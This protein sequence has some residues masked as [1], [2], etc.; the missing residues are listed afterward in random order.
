MEFFR[1]FSTMDSKNIEA[2]SVLD[3]LMSMRRF[4][5]L[6]ASFSVAIFERIDIDRECSSPCAGCGALVARDFFGISQGV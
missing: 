4:K 6:E 2:D 1:D 3:A 5:G